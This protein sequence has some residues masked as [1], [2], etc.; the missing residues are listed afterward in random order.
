VHFLAIEEGVYTVDEHGV[1]MEAVRANSSLVARRGNWGAREPRDYL[2]AYTNPV[3]VGQ[4]MTYN[5]TAWSS[6]WSSKRNTRTRPAT[7]GSFAAG[8]HV[9]EDNNRVRANEEIGYLVV[10][11]G[12]FNWNGRPVYSAVTSDLVLGVG[13]SSPGQS[14]PLAGIA[15]PSVAL[16]GSAG[17]DGRDGGWPVLF[18]SDPLSAEDITLAIDEDSI[19]D[20]ERRHTSEQVSILVFGQ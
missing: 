16:L 9:G 20:N 7:S 19:R 10:E 13:A 18:G 11:S 4:V 2:H 12:S 17:M 15:D 14:V 6:F 5:D 3:V 8:K 1:K